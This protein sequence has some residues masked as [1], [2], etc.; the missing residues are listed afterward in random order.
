M[1]D[2]RRFMEAGGKLVD[3]RRDITRRQLFALGLVLDA[4]L[5]LGGLLLTTLD[6][7]TA[8][9][10]GVGSLVAIVLIATLSEKS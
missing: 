6:P 2:L 7:E 8:F 1:D 5:T 9:L 10:G 3:A 4:T